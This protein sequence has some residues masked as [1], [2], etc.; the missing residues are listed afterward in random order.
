MCQN[1]ENYRTED[2]KEELKILL[3]ALECIGPKGE[4]KV[5][6][7]IRGSAIS[8]TNQYS[9]ESLSY[10]NHQGHNVSSAILSNPTLTPTDLASGK[11]IGFIPSAIDAASCHLGKIARQVKKAKKTALQVILESGLQKSLNKVQMKLMPMTFRGVVIEWKES[12][13]ILGWEDHI[14]LLPVWKIESTT[15]LPCHRS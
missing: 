4:V 5:G 7:W 2:Y 1:S 8:W 11:G 6:E 10:G 15:Y 9:I 3:D 13:D 12:R 14:L